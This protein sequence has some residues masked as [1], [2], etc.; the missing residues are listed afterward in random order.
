MTTHLSQT[1]DI[2]THMAKYDASVKEV[3]ADKQILARIL[4]Y[5]LEEFADYEIEAIIREMDEPQVSKVRMEPGQ[6]NLNKIEKTSEED[7]VLG[8]GKIYYD[9]RFCVYHGS[10]QIKILIN[11]EAQKSS[12]SSSLGYKLDN[13]IIYYL[14]RMISAQKE[15]EFTKSN[16]DDLK[17]VRSIWICMDSAD[18]EDSINR[19]RLTQEAVYGKDMK[20]DNLDKVMGVIIRLRS[21]ENVEISKNQLI[22]MLE[23]LLKKDEISRKKEKLSNKYGLIM[24]DNTE[25]R[26]GDM[27]NLSD[28]LVQESKAEGK[29]EGRA[30]GKAEGR[31][32]GENRLNQLYLLLMEE[33]RLDDLQKAT[34]DEKYRAVLY[35]E[36]HL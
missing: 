12:K 23:E 22:A 30:E 13:R 5:T 29:A 28:L 19:I 10:D 20:L 16:Y 9:I 33:N 3:L 35:A 21:N 36:F 26:L 18:H 11:V 17:H 7:N 24:N 1:I 31:V 25:R 2:T 6:T 34:K 15:V 14:G 32:E 27:C 4:K 8:E